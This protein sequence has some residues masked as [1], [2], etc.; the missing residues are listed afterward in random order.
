MIRRLAPLVA[1]A[2]LAVGATAAPA[3][4]D[5]EVGL[6]VDG[7]SWA[8]QLAAPLFDDDL[9]W[10]PGD[11]DD[12]SFLVRNDGPSAGEVTVDVI[13]TDPD[14]LLASDAFLL[15]ARVGTG[16]WVEVLAGN[17][18]LAPALLDIAEGAR[19]RITV[20]GTFDPETID[21][22]DQIAPFQVRVTMAEDGDIAG[23]DEG[24]DDGDVGGADDGILPDTGSG[25]GIGLI[26]LAA[27]LIGAGF[28]LVLPRRQ[29]REV[30]ARG[31][32]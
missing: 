8:N 12:A 27:G 23:V 22:Q 28:A 17:T 30:I 31:H 1:A 16:P 3:H 19:T 10:A 9:R 4:A 21:H 14:G 24:D 2:V 29:R 6:S 5:D 26:W 15:E 25:F 18:R 7:V 20:R 32:A 11:T 13:A